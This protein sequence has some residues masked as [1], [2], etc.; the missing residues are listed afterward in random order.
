MRAFV[1]GGSGFL[2]RTLIA[3][4]RQRGN[5]V[6]ALARSAEAAATVRAAGAEPARGDLADEA[7]VRRAA[8]DCA[9]VVHA[10][11]SVGG[12]AA[13]LHR[14]HVGGTRALLAAACAAGVPRVVLVSAAG[15]ILDGTPVVDADETRPLPRRFAGPYSRAK[16]EAERMV[17]GANAPDFRTVA[18]R[19]PL[20]WGAGDTTALPEIVRAARRSQWVWFD[21]GRYPYATCHVENVCEGIAVAAERGRGGEAYFLTDGPPVEFHHFMGDLIRTQGVDPGE[22]SVPWGAGKALATGLEVAWRVA[23]RPGAPALTREIAILMGPYTVR[24]DKARR[25]LG[26]TS[27]V[28]REAGLAALVATDAQATAG[29]IVPASA[30]GGAVRGMGEA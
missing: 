24:D 23:R 20:I 1:T 3:T 14:M 5:E 13:D 29:R 12:T 21:H 11:G 10:A 4:L 19:P 16:A 8:T 26:Y 9:V 25:E 6:R 22:R 17:L 18:V 30:T 2:G 7:S 27:A 28:S 15:I